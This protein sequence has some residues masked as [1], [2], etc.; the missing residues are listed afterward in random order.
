MRFV[1]LKASGS[2]FRFGRFWAAAVRLKLAKSDSCIY[3]PANAVKD[4][5][6]LATMSS[7]RMLRALHRTVRPQLLRIHCLR[8]CPV[9]VRAMS[10]GDAPH[11]SGPQTRMQKTNAKEFYCLTEKDVRA[12]LLPGR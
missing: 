11:G 7:F 8:I 9:R 4:K 2:S 3:V 12:A 10:T 1:G 5:V 6:H